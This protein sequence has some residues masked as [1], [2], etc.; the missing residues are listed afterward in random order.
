LGL[1]NKI[2]EELAKIDGHVTDLDHRCQHNKIHVE[3]VERDFKEDSTR[4]QRDR[5]DLRKMIEELKARL[6]KIEGQLGSLGDLE[7]LKKKMKDLE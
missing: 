7:E 3:Q 1:E 4:C 2:R 6:G 5:E